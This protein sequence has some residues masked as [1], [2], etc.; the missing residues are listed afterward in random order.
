MPYILTD[1]NGNYIKYQ[2]HNDTYVECS[3]IALAE[4]WMM[5]SQVKSIMYN[6]LSRNMKKRY[7]IEH[8]KEGGDKIIAEVENSDT[9]T[10]ED[11][12]I[13][14]TKEETPESH[15]SKYVDKLKE[16]ASETVDDSELQALQKNANGLI[17]SV[18]NLATELDQARYSLSIAD[19]KV[20]D[21]QH[22]IEFSSLNAYQGWLAQKALK[23]ALKSRRVAKD[24]IHILTSLKT[25]NLSSSDVSNLESSLKHIE[26]RVYTPRILTEIFE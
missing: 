3:N 20:A 13:L 5:K 25:L 19:Q 12:E 23:K 16:L 6:R 1:G 22:F 26:N 10:K 9:K 17:E 24:K 11:T 18:K 7:K 8:I 21:L 14:S 2:Q 4:R 15:T